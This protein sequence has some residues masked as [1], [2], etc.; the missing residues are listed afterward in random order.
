MYNYRYQIVKGFVMFL[1]LVYAQECN[2][3]VHEHLSGHVKTADCSKRGFSEV[4]QTLPRDITVLDLSGNKLRD[5][6]NFSFENYSLLRNVS[7]AENKL[8]IIEEHAFYGLSRLKYLNM[9]DNILNLKH[10]YAPEM[11][12]PLQNLTSLDIRRNI[13]N[14][15]NADLYHYPDQAFAVL[16][17]LEYLAIDMA[18]NPYFGIGFQGLKNLK[19]LTFEFCFLKYLRG[20]TF[21]NFSSSL[22]ELKLTRC[23]FNFLEVENN[24]LSPFPNITKIH[25]QESCMHLKQ[26]LNMLSPYNGKTIE[27]MNF[28]GL[29]CPIFN[30]NEYP[31]A[32]TVTQDMMRYLKTVCVET[33]DLSDNG[34]VDFDEN[35]LFSFDRPE[36]LKY[37]YFKGN[38]FAFA[39]GR[40]L[41][42]VKT[43]FNK[44]VALKTFDYS[45]IPVR[46]RLYAN[47]FR[48]HA[49]DYHFSNNI[50]YLPRSLEKLVLG[51]VLCDD[52]S[53]VFFIR[54]GSNL[55]YL[56]VSFSYTNNVV[57]FEGNAT[58]KTET[59]V[60]DGHYHIT[61]YTIELVSFINVKTLLW[62]SAK[63]F[64]IMHARSDDMFL[65]RFIALFK[66]FEYLEH[67]DMSDNDLF[68]LPENLLINIDHL[69]E[70]SLS[71]NLFQSIPSQIISQNN[72]K[73]LDL[74]KNLLPTV[75]YETRVWADSMNQK[76]GF[77]FLLDDNAFECNC[78]NLDFIDWIQK[79]KVHL[80]NRV[81]NCTLLNGTVITVLEAYENMHD[82]FSH[83][84][85]SIWL[86]VSSTLLGTSC[87][88]AVIL[89]LYSRRWKIAIFFYRIFRKIVEKKYGKK[90]TYDVFVSYGGDCIPWIKK[91]FIPKLEDEW[92]L[93]I[94][95]KDRDFYGGESFYDAEAESI[96]NSRH[97]IFLLT[98]I[99]KVS[100]DCL[101]E[102]DRVK[103]EISMQNIENIIVIS[104]D[105]TLKDIPEG[106]T[107]IWNYVLFIQWPED[108]ND[109]DFTWL[110][111]RKWISSDYLY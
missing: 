65:K 94:C 20:Y 101:F 99:F 90:Y 52:I 17:K 8:H 31:F 96:E 48:F 102:I 89:L 46:Y 69:S 63:L 43:F 19:S 55:T 79:T 85:N 34:I 27:I 40:Q 32:L 3:T 71:K 56:D 111:L 107:H 81:Y 18:P 2:I 16:K 11:L 78:D 10:V 23:H 12:L 6:S 36:C 72:I 73:V 98:P 1:S 15:P 39:Y 26:A 24:A 37:L 92:K 88:M 97:V 13:Q 76:H 22:D 91:Y 14:Q 87:I 64:Y 42:E 84:R 33:L 106:L 9:S 57:I 49:P 7:L 108:C 82:L 54:R 50:I 25:F 61:L 77:Y 68:N 47:D 70:L 103:H 66:K 62:R 109:H 29:N 4:P 45:F 100:Q 58:Y 75:D 44:S 30:N 53:R 95:V 60:L 86:M 67:L 105:I 110:K 74:S 59:L 83:C 93:K 38:R 35:S 21:E 41:D 5:I 28:R 104:K 51:N 80:D